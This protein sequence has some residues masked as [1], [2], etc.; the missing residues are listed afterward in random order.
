VEVIEKEPHP[1]DPTRGRMRSRLTGINQ[2]G[3]AVIS[4]IGLGMVKRR[5]PLDEAPGGD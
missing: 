3:E 5:E 1:T 2:E 4:W